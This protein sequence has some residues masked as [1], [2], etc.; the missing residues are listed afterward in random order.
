MQVL[1]HYRFRPEERT[2][3]G[4]CLGLERMVCFVYACI[5]QHQLTAGRVCFRAPLWRMGV[6]KTDK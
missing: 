4:G 1:D 5:L 2:E 3:T 6:M